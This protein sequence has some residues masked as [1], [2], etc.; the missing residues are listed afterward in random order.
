ML[1]IIFTALSKAADAEQWR[2][3]WNSQLPRIPFGARSTKV[4]FITSTC[5]GSPAH[6]E[7]FGQ[8]GST[9]FVLP[10]EYGLRQFIILIPSSGPDK[11][12][13]SILTRA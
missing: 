13:Y 9:V 10:V 6:L 3:Q 4:N 1:P 5:L 12:T 11:P 2:T 7:A 8:D